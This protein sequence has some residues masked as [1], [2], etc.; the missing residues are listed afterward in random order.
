MLTIVVELLVAL[1]RVVLYAVYG[2]FARL[3]P[4]LVP[5]KD[6]AG[7]IV[8][9]TGAGQGIGA[10]MAQKIAALGARLVLWDINEGSREGERALLVRDGFV[11]SRGRESSVGTRRL[12]WCET[13]LRYLRPW[14]VQ[15]RTDVV[16]LRENIIRLSA[17]RTF[18]V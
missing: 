8:L 13:A 2:V 11:G 17:V 5:K 18:L 6:I 10:L 9:V 3:C 1:V 12:C 16:G 15:K 7:R 14:S 4:F